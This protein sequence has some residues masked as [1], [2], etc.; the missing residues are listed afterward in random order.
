MHAARG[1]VCRTLVVGGASNFYAII[2]EVLP[3]ENLCRCKNEVEL[4]GDNFG[5]FI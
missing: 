3:M 4:F 5:V 2:L 1:D